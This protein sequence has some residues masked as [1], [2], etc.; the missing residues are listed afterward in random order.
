MVLTF[1]IR[2]DNTDP[3]SVRGKGLGKMADGSVAE[4]L[5]SLACVSFTHHG[6]A[7]RS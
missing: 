2:A 4:I 5:D 6:G 1:W 3:P 7:S